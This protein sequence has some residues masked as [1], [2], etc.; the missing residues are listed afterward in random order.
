[1]RS[2]SRARALRQVSPAFLFLATL[3]VFLMALRPASA[4]EVQ[5]VV[6]PGGIE[7]W[8]VEDHTLPLLSIS[9]AF[10]G[11]SA[12]DPAGKAGVANMVS[13]L[14]D[15]GAGDLDSETFQQKLADLSIELNFDAGRDGFFGT[16]RALTRYR[17]EAT[18]LLR[19]ALTQPRFDV[20]PV[21]RIRG[22]ILAGMARQ[23][24]EPRD[25]A[26]KAFWQTVLPGHPY[27]NPV[28]GTQESVASLTPDDFRKFVADRFGRDTLK[29]GVAGDITPAELGVLLDRTFGA[30]PAKSAPIAIPDAEPAAT[31]RTIVIR[32]NVPQS[33]VLFGQRGIKRDDPDFYAAFVLN[34]LLGGG[35][36][37]SRLYEEV[38]EKRGLAY[39]AYSYLIP[40]DHTALWIGSAATANPR[41]G[42]TLAVVRNVWT[43]MRDAPVDEA[44]LDDAK[45]NI[46]GSYALRLISS[47]AIARTL[48]G[49]QRDN[50]GIDYLDRR[51]ALID[52][53]TAADI[54]RVAKRLLE[55]DSLTVIVVGEPDGV[56]STPATDSRG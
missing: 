10:E 32:Q 25:I 6:S 31:G 52:A 37:S 14:L 34:H 23:A 5:R 19:A 1:M 39:G 4:V 35:T 20:R 41:V 44:A 15:E 11:G 51:N 43:E 50:L 9:L 29:V 3:A 22:Q 7:A 47:R 42:K 55:P 27:A 21:E 8:L 13:G 40:L 12:T 28:E 46:T 48:V 33:T 49:L 17:D 30:L 26:G 38:R 16:M 53:V 2:V 56:A 36:F 24:N 18:D 45:R 54:S